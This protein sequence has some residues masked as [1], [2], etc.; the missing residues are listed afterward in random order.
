MRNFGLLILLAVAVSSLGCDERTEQTDTGG[1]LL[2][3]EFSANNV[4]FRFSVNGDVLDLQSAVAGTLTISSV[5]PNVENPATSSL[6]DVE[7]EG[8]EFTY[9]RVDR[10][11]RV[12][13]PFYF[14]LLG[15]VPAGGTLS[16]NGMPILSI[17]QISNPPIS[18]LLFEN[19]GFDKETGETVITMNVWVRA[20]GRT[21]SGREVQS[22]PRP[23][24]IEF[25]Q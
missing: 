3:V 11:T 17:E 12:P 19:G 23:H 4:P 8:L 24:T 21:L 18:D 20:Y 6:M 5:I 13:A 22:V 16:Y 2:E 15:T 1:V 14:N 10:G 9:T 25:T 7:L